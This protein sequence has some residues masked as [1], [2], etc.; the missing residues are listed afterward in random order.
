M[1]LASK[2]TFLASVLSLSAGYL[3][4]LAVN[5]FL[6]PG[7]E[8]ARSSGVLRADGHY[9]RFVTVRDCTATNTTKHESPFGPVCLS[10]EEKEFLHNLVKAMTIVMARSNDHAWKESPCLSKGTNVSFVYDER[11]YDV[12]GNTRE[13][14]RVKCREQIVGKMKEEWKNFE[15]NF[16]QQKL[17]LTGELSS[18]CSD[19][20]LASN[21]PVSMAGLK[22]LSQKGNPE[23][24]V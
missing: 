15:V 3:L 7:V 10:G 19:L 8:A 6:R 4:W 24:S 22:V 11:E 20:G 5:E 16:N 23:R 17:Y 13:Y 9:L 2:N 18:I 12:K 1:T 21:T 14:N